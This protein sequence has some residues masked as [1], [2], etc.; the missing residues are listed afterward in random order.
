MLTLRKVPKHRHMLLSLT[1]KYALLVLLQLYKIANLFT[2]RWADGMG[3]PF[4]N[5]LPY[6]QLERIQRLVEDLCSNHL[7]KK[8][9]HKSPGFWM[10]TICCIV[11]LDEESRMY[12]AKS[13]KS[14]REIYHDCVAVLVIDPWLTSI[15]STAPVSEIARRIYASGWSRRLWTHQEGFLGRDVSYQFQDRPLSF[16]EVDELT[17]EYERKMAVKGYP[18]TF[19]YTASSK[20]SFYYTGIKNI[21]ENIREGRFSKDDR[22]IVYRHLA[23]SLG[24]R[25]TTNVDDELLCVA[26]VIGLNVGDYIKHKNKDDKYSSEQSDVLWRAAGLIKQNA[27][28]NKTDDYRKYSFF[29]WHY[30]LLRS[31]GTHAQSLTDQFYLQIYTDCHR[32]RW[33]S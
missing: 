31:T 1:C 28:S 4:D 29:P 27:W 5:S 10:D 30:A 9:T 26:S 7:S 18:I 24:H 8:K 12:K 19:P 2:G 22:W 17:K 33:P 14:M 32:Q 23:E 16:N 21:I 11:G 25:S 20:T 13:I 15:P 3:N 6:C